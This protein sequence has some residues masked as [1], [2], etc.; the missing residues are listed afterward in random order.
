MQQKIVIIDYGLGNLFSIQQA[1]LQLGVETVLTNDQQVIL[2]ADALI[3][4]GVGAFDEA[5]KNLRRLNLVETIQAFAASQKPILGVCLGLQLLFSKSFEHG[6]HEG[7]GLIEG[8]VEKFPELDP[9]GNLLRIPHVG[10]NQIEISDPAFSQFDAQ[11]FYFV[12]S[13]YVKPADE[14]V[15]FSKSTYNGF[16]F[17][18]A[19]KT[20]H[21][22]ATQ[23]HPEKS[24]E[25]GLSLFKTWI[26]SLN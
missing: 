16:E 1:F 3:L 9:D 22:F 21:I 8:T 26:D 18:S 19:I 12:H 23:F 20:N 15:I 4:P 10:W 17:C 2:D 5:M 7:L 25:F 13:Y 6:E 14:Q 24:G 11:H